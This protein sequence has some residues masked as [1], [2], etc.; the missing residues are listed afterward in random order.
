MSEKK[1]NGL[2]RYQQAVH[3]FGHQ[4]VLQFDIL[5]LSEELSHVSSSVT[6]S[7]N[8][9]YIKQDFDYDRLQADLSE[10]LSLISQIATTFG[11]KLSE[12]ATIKVNK[13]KEKQD[14]Q[15]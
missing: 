11:M 2:D 8:D 4:N 3:M 10:G 7:V 14:G 6:T 12:L 9:Y 15:E 13:L 1:G 5:R